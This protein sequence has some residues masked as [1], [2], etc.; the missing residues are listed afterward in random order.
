MVCQDASHCKSFPQITTQATCE[1]TTVC[2][3]PNG[4]Y[5][6]NIT[7]AECKAIQ[8]GKC[9]GSC[10]YKCSSSVLPT[11]AGCYV[12]AQ[13]TLSTAGQSNSLC[14][15]AG[16]VFRSG[17]CL[18]PMKS[19]S[20]CLSVYGGTYYDCGVHTLDECG[21][22]MRDPSKC[23]VNQT[24]MSC[25]SK[26]KVCDSPTECMNGGRCSN[27]ETLLNVKTGIPKPQYY[28]ACV[29]PRNSPEGDFIYPWCPLGTLPIPNAC[30][31]HSI[32]RNQCS[33]IGG[34]WTVPSTTKD[35]C[36][37]D[38]GCSEINTHI[39]YR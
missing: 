7:E 39:A 21:D 10:G 32:P 1:A 4:T 20:N 12:T 30:V 15:N 29:V 25:I 31:A 9:L 35:N 22:C 23:L 8:N 28:G 18:I 38:K 33:L 27:S 11:D 16:G 14:T 37:K 5:A 19:S 2:I 34:N 36:L 6:I 13:S 26:D 24:I 17:G 3:L